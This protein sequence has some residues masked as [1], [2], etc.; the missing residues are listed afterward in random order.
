MGL[1]FT[2]TRPEARSNQVWLDTDV[3]YGEMSSILG[4]EYVLN[5][6]AFQFLR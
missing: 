3:V 2:R 6:G 4:L 5:V 1:I